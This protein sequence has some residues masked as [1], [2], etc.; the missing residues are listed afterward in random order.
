MYHTESKRKAPTH[1]GPV[2]HVQPK[3]RNE[4]FKR[5]KEKLLKKQLDKKRIEVNSLK[6][7]VCKLLD[8]HEEVKNCR[9]EIKVLENQLKQRKF[10]H[11]RFMG[12][13]NN[14]LFYT[15]LTNDQ[16]NT[17][18]AF[19]GPQICTPRF[20]NISRKD[21]LFAVFIKCRLSLQYKD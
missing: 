7:Q 8:V 1:G 17:L 11:E 9:K 15:G 13:D 16:F 4:Y 19:L 18:W 5:Y 21:E 12:D 2:P 6:D 14:M 3:P 20:E 10:T